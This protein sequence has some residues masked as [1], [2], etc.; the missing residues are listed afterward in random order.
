MEPRYNEPPC[1]E[2]LEI[3]IDFLYPINSKTVSWPFVISRFHRMC[4]YII[5][6]VAQSLIS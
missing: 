1:Y 2:A 3:T 6:T 5:P 4:N